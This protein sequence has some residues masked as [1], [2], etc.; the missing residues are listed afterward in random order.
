MAK[1]IKRTWKTG[2]TR[3]VA[4]GYT[5]QLG[6]KQVRKFDSAWTKDDA[7][8]AMAVRILE[9]EQAAAPEPPPPPKTFGQVADEYLEFKQAKG[10]KTLEDDRRHLTRWRAAL[11]AETPITAITGQQV[12]AYDRARAVETSK[13]GRTITPASV[14]RELAVLR[15]LLRLAE[16]WG[17]I[18]KAPRVR[19]GRE[20]QGRLRYLEEPE[21]VR[22]LDACNATE[23]GHPEKLKHPYLGAIVTIALHTGMRRGEIL[24]LT[25]ER[26]DFARGVLKLELTK[27]G[28]RREVP[29]NQPVYAALTA[30]PGPKTEGYVFRKGD[31]AAW[32]SIRTAF[33]TACTEAKLDDFRFHD[34][35]HTCASWLVMRGRSLKE[36]QEILGHQTFAMTLRYAH[37]SPDRLREAVASLESFST[38]S[39]HEAV[40][41]SERPVST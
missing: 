37:L 38:Q 24:G 4:Y 5:L 8:D 10:K 15:H 7:R 1:V 40:E 30:L 13:L 14:N 41:S 18:P 29:M 36:V 33:A 27:S 25:W 6:D 19:M 35:R 9:I 32:G 3:H 31:G 11:G 28:R 17:Y 2:R 26:V 20:P 12:A 23:E 16:E 21:A 39:A 22:L 34:L